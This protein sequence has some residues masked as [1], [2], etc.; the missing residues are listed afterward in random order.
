[1]KK[2]EAEHFFST[3]VFFRQLMR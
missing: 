2:A 1:M 3:F